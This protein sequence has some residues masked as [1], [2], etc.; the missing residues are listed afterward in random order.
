MQRARRSSSRRPPPDE[1]MLKKV[2]AQTGYELKGIRS[3]S[4][5][6]KTGLFGL[7]RKK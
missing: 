4:A 7:F 6:E 1:E 5:P 2:I 3:E